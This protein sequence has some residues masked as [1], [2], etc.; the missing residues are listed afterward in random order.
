VVVEPAGTRHATITPYGPF[1]AADG[2]TLNIAVQNDRQWAMLCKVL[3][4]DDLQGDDRVSTNHGRLR[5]RE[6][7]ERAVAVAVAN[8]PSAELAQALDRE[9]IP[10]GQLNGTADVVRHPQL[11]AA[12]RWRP[13][14]LPGGETVTVL[15]PPFLP[16]GAETQHDVPRVPDLGE[17]TDEVLRPLRASG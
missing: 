5:W 2:K 9:G 8:W 3:H 12:K 17:H 13:V 1:V 4:L 15:A 14:R 7:V 10:W 16:S 11:E 6:E